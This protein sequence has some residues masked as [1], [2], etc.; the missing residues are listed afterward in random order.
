MPSFTIIARVELHKDDA[1][2]QP[3]P[4]NASEY[5]T[6]HAEMWKRGFRRFFIG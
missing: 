6:L 1:R 3:H 4:T 2:K 5:T